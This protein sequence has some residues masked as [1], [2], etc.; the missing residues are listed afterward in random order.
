MKTFRL[1]IMGVALLVIFPAFAKAQISSN[2]AGLAYA[3]TIDTVMSG[4]LLDVQATV[5]ADRKYVTL[6]MRPQMSQLLDMKQFSYGGTTGPTTGTSGSGVNGGLIGVG[7]NTV[8]AMAATGHYG[9]VNPP[10]TLG[11]GSGA[12]LTQRGMTQILS[13]K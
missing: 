13:G 10:A 11:T 4:V 8:T 3:P 1:S 2:G 5:S 7:G 6:T 12:V 9:G